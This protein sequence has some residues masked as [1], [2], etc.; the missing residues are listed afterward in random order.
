MSHLNANKTTHFALG[1][2]LAA[3]VT[4]FFAGGINMGVITPHRA[5]FDPAAATWDY[6]GAPTTIRTGD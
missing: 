6:E 3:A 2:L 4:A 5:P 1:A